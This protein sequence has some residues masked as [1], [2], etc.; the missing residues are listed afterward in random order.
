MTMKQGDLFVDGRIYVHLVVGFF[1]G[2][3]ARRKGKSRA[4]LVNTS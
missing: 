3:I 1:I 4:W 2:G